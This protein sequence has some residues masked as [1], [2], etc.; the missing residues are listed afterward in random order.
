MFFTDPR[1][2][3]IEMGRVTAA[4]YR[5]EG[6]RLGGAGRRMLAWITGNVFGEWAVRAG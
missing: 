1:A 6:D 5:R 4:A 3:L 2:A